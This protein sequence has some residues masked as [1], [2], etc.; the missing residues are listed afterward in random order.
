[1]T[2]VGIQIF[3]VCLTLK[4]PEGR[5]IDSPQTDSTRDDVIKLQLL[6]INYGP[7]IERIRKFLPRHG[8]PQKRQ[9]RLDARGKQE[10]K[11]NRGLR[12]SRPFTS[13]GDVLLVVTKIKTKI[14]WSNSKRVKLTQNQHVFYVICA[15]R[16]LAFKSDL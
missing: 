11:T 15:E 14:F 3:T 12:F 10:R 13:G 6:V 8:C 1:M 5:I 4:S 9:P 7:T 2:A 16:A